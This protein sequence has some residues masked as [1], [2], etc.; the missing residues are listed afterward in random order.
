M[1]HKK[2]I[3]L[4]SVACILALSVWVASA[5]NLI[6]Q[7]SVLAGRVVAQNL[8]A[9]GTA[10]KEGTILV[11]VESITGAAVAA[12]ATRDGVVHEVLVKPGDLIKVGQV[13]ARIEP[14]A[15]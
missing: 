10:V 8:V 6:D 9:V 7:Q 14:A 15:K 5:V 13:V 11:R 2:T 1:L 12:R 3:I 4:L